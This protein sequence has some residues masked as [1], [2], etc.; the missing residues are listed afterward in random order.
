MIATLR[1]LLKKGI[2]TIPRQGLTGL[3]TGPGRPILDA[4][5]CDGCGTCVAVCPTQALVLDARAL[6]SSLRVDYGACIS[7]MECV[8]AC[9]LKAWSASGEPLPILSERLELV[10]SYPI[11]IHDRY[12]TE[13]D[14]D[15]DGS[16]ATRI[17]TD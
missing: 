6:E 14:V 11:T 7:C 12:V 3:P 17:L 1:R 15:G 9:Q 13:G 2:G 16:R 8:S 10:R 5:A 4:A